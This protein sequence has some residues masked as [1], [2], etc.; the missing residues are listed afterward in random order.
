MNR[1]RAVLFL[2]LGVVSVACGT[3]LPSL[4]A[5]AVQ[6]PTSKLRF[7]RASACANDGSVE[8]CV[9][10]GDDALRQRLLALSTELRFT[11]QRGRAQCEPTSERLVMFPTAKGPGGACETSTI[12][13]SAW[14]TICGLAAEPA[15]RVIVPTLYE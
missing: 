15:V 5:S 6:C 3:T 10:L 2:L 14:T 9:P 4:G 12:A 8:F 11:S 13:D 1:C 7:T